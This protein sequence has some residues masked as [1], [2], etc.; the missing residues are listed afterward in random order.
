MA[1]IVGG[2]AVDATAAEID[3]LD[4]LDRGSIIY[5]NASS[6]TSIL[7]NGTADQ[8]LTSDGDDISWEAGGGSGT[9]NKLQEVTSS[10]DAAEVDLDTT[11]DD[12]YDQYKITFMTLDSTS[13]NAQVWI[14]LE[15]G[16]T[17][18]TAGYAYHI[19]TNTKDTA[20]YQA[21]NYGSAGGTE[22]I[23]SGGTG[24]GNVS[25]GEVRFWKPSDTADTNGILISQLRCT[26][27]V[28][29]GT[30]WHMSRSE[31]ITG[32]RFLFSAGTI[33]DGAEFI[34]WGMTK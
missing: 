3:V 32:V 8:V 4:G 9:W 34:L 27:G 10:G 2:V 11:I 12:T 26:E 6:V 7:D 14:R 33:V 22:A 28:S 23:K 15:Y 16:G 29:Y 18:Y 21:L 31:A 5:G 30:G 24:T 25:Y 1:L 20:S 17:W 19:S 13:D